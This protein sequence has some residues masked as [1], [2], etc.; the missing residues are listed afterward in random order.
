MYKLC[1]RIEI[2]SHLVRRPETVR[3]RRSVDTL[4]DTAEVVLPGMLHGKAIEIE[5]HIAVGDRVKIALGYDNELKS[6]FEGYVSRIGTDG[7]SIKIE[8][9]DQLW[10]TRKP[11]SDREFRNVTVNELL[12]AVT[13][14]VGGGELK[15]NCLYDFKYDKFT[16]HN[17][18]GWDVLKKVQDEVK[19]NIFINNGIL[20]VVPKYMYGSAKE[21][22]YDF[23]RNIEKGGTGLEYR[24]EEDRRVLVVVEGERR[25]G[26]KVRVEEGVTGGDRVTLKLPGVT[27]EESMRTTA[28]Q[29]LAEKSYTGYSGSFSSWLRPAV[30]PTNI[31]VLH[32]PDYE[33][34][35]GSYW[36]TA[37]E[38]EYSRSGGKRKITLGK[39][40][41]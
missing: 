5:D 1:H 31:A 26:T 11:V 10:L 4:A 9:E 38:T 28:K 39:R 21:V 14:E 3:V 12:E 34:K 19:P 7:G 18:T 36:I 25:D 6:E 16:I 22:E 40:L 33:Y 2:G 41:S 13:T 32:D 24:R 15:V 35:D 27:D 29:V 8:C 23:S 17:A 30:E 20:W 37:V